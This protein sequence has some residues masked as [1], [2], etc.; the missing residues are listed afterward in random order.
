M[1]VRLQAYTG[2]AALSTESDFGAAASGPGAAVDG[3]VGTTVLDSEA[4][5][6]RFPTWSAFL[7]FFILILSQKLNGA[8]P[9][10]G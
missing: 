3:L 2:C 9:F 8:K 6:L 5:V 4:N 7:F 10:I 1:C